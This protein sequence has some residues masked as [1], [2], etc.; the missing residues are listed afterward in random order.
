L[1]ENDPRTRIEQ[2]V[3]PNLDA[4]YN[5]ARWLTGNEHDASDVTQEACLRAVKFFDGFRGGDSRTWIL[6]I[7]RNTCSTWRQ[8]NQA[9]STAVPFDEETHAT[10]DAETA[11]DAELLSRADR[12][13]V[14]EALDALPPDYREVIVLREFE[15]MSYKQIA[16]VVNI[17]LG[18]V[19][20]RLDRART[21]LE[22]YL[23]VRLR[24]EP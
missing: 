23:A 2:A 10:S 22:S 5:L 11:P 9:Q 16:A 3:L 14:R 15:E 20:S 6:K 4:A 17:P 7:V 21:R 13:L 18:T 1:I 19:M 12:E 24:E 8:R